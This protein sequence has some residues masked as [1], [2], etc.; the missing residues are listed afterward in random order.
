MLFDPAVLVERPLQVLAVAAIIIVGKSVAA[1]GL[2]LLLRYPLG[3]ALT[4]SASLA[5]I[6]EFSFILVAMGTSLQVLPPEASSLVVAGAIL[7]IA[8]N[9]AVFAAVAPLQ[10]WLLAHAQWARNLHAR[11]EPLAE[12]PQDTADRFLHDQVVLVGWGTVGRRI[13]A[14]LGQAGR[15]L[16]VVDSSRERVEAM[17]AKGVVAVAGDATDPNT[18]IQAHITDAQW[19]VLATSDATDVRP[20][21]EVARALNPGIRIAA[22]AATE[23]EAE[24]LRK[25]GAHVVLAPREALAQALGHAVLDA[26]AAT[27][28]P[29]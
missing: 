8:L 24:L 16:V 10:K 3:T 13:A 11:H 21:M 23:Q 19:L 6:G 14:T 27:K 15:P 22:R 9:P 29:E 17:R 20:M 25:A 26:S 2:V 4:V 7:S 5:Q 28:P 12:L 1:A 18:L